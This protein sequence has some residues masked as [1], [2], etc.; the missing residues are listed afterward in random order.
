MF[1]FV[2]MEKSSFDYKL[3]GD[4][5]VYYYTPKA[6]PGDKKSLLNI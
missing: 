4:C 6:Y 3:H 5:F 1:N 2:I